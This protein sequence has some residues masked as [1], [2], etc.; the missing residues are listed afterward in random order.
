MLFEESGVKIDLTQRVHFNLETCPAYRSLSG[1]HFKVIDIGW[2]EPA[3]EIWYLVEVKDFRK[4]HFE[5]RES[6]KYIINALTKK[7]IDSA[8]MLMALQVKSSYSA[9]IAECLPPEF[10]ITATSKFRF[11]HILHCSAS[12]EAQMGFI[13]DEVQARFTA[14][15]KLFGIASCQVVSHERAKRYLEVVS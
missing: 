12:L 13:K 10:K 2:Y 11:V 5:S 14:Y 8:C 7:S 3:S 6:V 9:A 4:H 1:N 15:Q